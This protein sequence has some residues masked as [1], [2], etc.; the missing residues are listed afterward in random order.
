VT[1]SKNI[2]DNLPSLAPIR[3][4]ALIHELV[5]YLSIEPENVASIRWWYEKQKTFPP[6]TPSC[7]SQ[8][9]HQPTPPSRFC[10]YRQRPCCRQVFPQWWVAREL[11]RAGTTSACVRLPLVHLDSND[12]PKTESANAMWRNHRRPS[13]QRSKPPCIPPQT[14]NH[15]RL[16]AYYSVPSATGSS[17]TTTTLEHAPPLPPAAAPT[18]KIPTF[19]R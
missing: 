3:T 9:L 18:A 1:T 6:S 5:L 4:A 19:C 11:T 2:F 10:S 13:G 15:Q 16:S 8:H 7:P 17:P 14:W 12:I